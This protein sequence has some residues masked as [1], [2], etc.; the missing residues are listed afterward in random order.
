MFIGG[1][2]VPGILRDDPLVLPGRNGNIVTLNFMV[3]NVIVEG[4]E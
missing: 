4:V 1:E 3:A 2:R